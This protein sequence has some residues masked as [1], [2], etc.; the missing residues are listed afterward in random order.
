MR[1]FG[2]GVLSPQL[3]W[4]RVTPSGGPL[5]E[6]GYAYFANRYRLGRI[7]EGWEGATTDYDGPFASALERGALLACQFH[8]E[9]SG[10]FGAA[11]MR[12]WL[13]RG[14]EVA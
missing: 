5:L 14:Q 12:R 13:Q 4:N 3:G 2:P 7:P 10:A 11:L 9:L 6:E 1:S 8:P